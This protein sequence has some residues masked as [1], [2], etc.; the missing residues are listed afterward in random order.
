M[1]D[2]PKL[3]TPSERLALAN[4]MIAEWCEEFRVDG[5]AV[6]PMLADGV[7]FVRG[8]IADRNQA[9]F[10]HMRWHGSLEA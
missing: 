9:T 4:E 2:A 10:F 1:T 5:D 8:E 6:Y 3:G 7:I